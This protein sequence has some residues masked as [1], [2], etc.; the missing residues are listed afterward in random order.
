MYTTPH[1]YNHPQCSWYTGPSLLNYLD[2]M[3]PIS[4]MPE[5]PLRLPIVDRYKDMGTIVLGKVE[6]GTISRGSVYTMMPNRVRWRGG[7]MGFAFDEKCLVIGN[8]E[9]YVYNSIH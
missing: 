5:G 8:A 6:S 4:R 7:E 9:V 3:Q 1:S 2:E